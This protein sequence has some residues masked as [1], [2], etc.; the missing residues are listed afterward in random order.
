MSANDLTGPQKR[1]I[2]RLII[3]PGQESTKE[4]LLKIVPNCI[5]DES[6]KE[7]S[8]D[9][10]LL[11]AEVPE[12]RDID[13][14]ARKN[15]NS[16]VAVRKNPQAQSNLKNTKNPD[17]VKKQSNPGK[18]PQAQ[19]QSNLQKMKR[20]QNNKR[21]QQQK[22]K[23]KGNMKRQFQKGSIVR[24][25]GKTYRVVEVLDQPMSDIQK[26]R[27]FQR[28]QNQLRQQS[29]SPAKGQSAA[30]IQKKR[31]LQRQQNKRRQQNKQ[32]KQVAAAKKHSLQQ[33]K[34]AVVDS[35]NT[36]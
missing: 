1:D 8:T 18:N 21:A 16:G 36:K 32:R 35:N 25:H 11:A 10:N 7:N 20:K 17:G 34:T 13:G 6:I 12:S 9:K 27:Q 30:N 31:Q 5:N 3:G 26:R 22:R 33:M 23:N 29:Q 19:A 4:E 28:R 14:V 24:F 15:S 2:S